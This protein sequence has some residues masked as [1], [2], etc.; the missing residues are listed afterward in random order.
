M[1]L[2][3]PEFDGPWCRFDSTSVVCCGRRHAV[4]QVVPPTVA[5]PQQV[6]CRWAVVESEAAMHREGWVGLRQ[7]FTAPVLITG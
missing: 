2:L 5:V 4:T 6:A 7:P 3:L 1:S